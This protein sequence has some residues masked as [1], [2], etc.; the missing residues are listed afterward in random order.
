MPGTVRPH[1]GRR[2]H[3]EMSVPKYSSPIEARVPS[4]RELAER[5]V[6]LRDETRV[7]AQRER[8]HDLLLGDLERDLHAR[9]AGRREVLEGTEVVVDRE[10]DAAVPMTA[11]NGLCEAV[12][13]STTSR[14]PLSARARPVGRRRLGGWCGPRSRPRPSAR[15]RPPSTIDEDDTKYGSRR[16]CPGGALVVDGDLVRDDV[17]AA[18]PRR[19][20]KIRS[21]SSRRTPA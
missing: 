19:P 15:C 18:W 21:T 2:R 10:V 6:D 7:L 20:A 12:D 13:R 3:F 5:L 4:A 17:I 16:S 14:L 9:V 1:R 8:L 11:V